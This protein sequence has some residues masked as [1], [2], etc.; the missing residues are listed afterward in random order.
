MTKDTKVAIGVGVAALAIGGL[1]GYFGFAKKSTTAASTTPQFVQGQQ[2]SLVVADAS[3]TTD[4]NE[5]VRR[6]VASMWSPAAFPTLV[7]QAQVS[8]GT[9][10]LWSVVATRTGPTIPA[11]GSENAALQNL[12]LAQASGGGLPAQLPA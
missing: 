11:T 8:G 6:L 5:I 2:Y 10:N 12:L 1:I 4:P 7:G 9:A 3:G